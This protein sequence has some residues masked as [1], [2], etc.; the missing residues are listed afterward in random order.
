MSTRILDAY[1]Y[2]KPEAE[3]MKE[4]N[5]IRDAFHEY[6]KAG[7]APQRRNPVRAKA[8]KKSTQR[9]R[10]EGWLFCIL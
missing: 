2:D 1:L 10:V 8:I 5:S 7:Q 6:L 9:R 3:L 4:L